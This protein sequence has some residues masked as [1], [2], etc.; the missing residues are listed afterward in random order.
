VYDVTDPVRANKGFKTLAKVSKLSKPR[1]LKI[2]NLN[3]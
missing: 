2:T 3:R 1:K